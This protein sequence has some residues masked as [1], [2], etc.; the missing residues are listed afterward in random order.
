M[1]ATLEGFNLVNFLTE[2][3]LP[4][5][6]L[7]GGVWVYFAERKKRSTEGRLSINDATEGM[8]SMYDKFVNDANYQYDKL[9]EKITRLQ[10]NEYRALE[11][12]DR[13]S[14][15]LN[16]V[17]QEI[18]IDKHRILELESKILEYEE[19]IKQYK[20]Q[21]KSLTTELNKYKNKT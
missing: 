19:A 1:M 13:L 14:L 2:N 7:V 4:F 9:N 11:E 5:S 3:W 15:E 12:R 18:A 10:E 17:K 8:Q 21:V 6:T 16:R 20:L